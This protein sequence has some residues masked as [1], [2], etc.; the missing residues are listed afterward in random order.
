MRLLSFGRSRTAIPPSVGVLVGAV[1][2]SVAVS[3]DTLLFEEAPQVILAVLGLLFLMNLPVNAFW[4]SVGVLALSRVGRL[5]FAG[6]GLRG[7]KLS[8]RVLGAAALIT[9]LVAL[10]DVSSG[11][12]E[13]SWHEGIGGTAIIALAL[14][15]VSVLAV[16][17]AVLR[18]G[19]V[20]S[21]AV[22]S[23]MAV[24]NLVQWVV[25]ATVFYGDGTSENPAPMLVSYG[26]VCAVLSLLTYLRIA[27]MPQDG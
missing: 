20:P 25:I 15:F 10:V 2:A 24:V 14:V 18:L 27:K 22:A 1:A 9:L 19:L 17:L 7:R 16:S 12:F 21:L 8:K 23:G 26:L 4:Y 3:A 6:P 5:D 13:P 11:G